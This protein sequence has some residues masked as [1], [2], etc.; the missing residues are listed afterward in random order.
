MKL[1]EIN[2]TK[3]NSNVISDYPHINLILRER[4]KI[5]IIYKWH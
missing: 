5:V 3:I 1:S 4:I 2:F